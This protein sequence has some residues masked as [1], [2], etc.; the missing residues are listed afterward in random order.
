[1][2]KLFFI[3]L[4][5]VCS[6]NSQAGIRIV[7]LNCPHITTETGYIPDYDNPITW[8][9]E[10]EDGTIIVGGV[11]TLISYDYSCIP[12]VNGKLQFC[13]TLQRDADDD[14][15]LKNFIQAKISINGE[16]VEKIYLSQF[17]KNTAYGFTNYSYIYETSLP[18]G[19][20][21]FD[22]VVEMLVGLFLKNGGFAYIPIGEN[23]GFHTIEDNSPSEI[24]SV[25]T[26]PVTICDEA[27][28]DASIT[29]TVEICE[30]G[31]W[32]DMAKM[33]NG[34]E[35]HK[36]NKQF[37]DELI[38]V[39][40]NPFQDG[41]HIVES[42]SKSLIINLY[43]LQGKILKQ[44][45]RKKGNRLLNIEKMETADLPIGSYI[46]EIKTDFDS[47]NFKLLKLK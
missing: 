2:K 19:T 36:N 45:I 47:K 34:G 46:C 4:L 20:V 3:L 32:F 10:M 40:P 41:I 7:K 33:S 14:L 25:F 29:N 30:N 11:P 8:E 43:D 27:I 17:S 9:Q 23:M 22:L 39:Y 42:V 44:I 24:L 15:V 31:D 13:L 6:Y 21:G 28:N 35:L 1:M 18:I 38:N 12:R 37:N 26:M 5:G 16:E